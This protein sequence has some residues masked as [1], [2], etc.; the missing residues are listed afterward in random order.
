VGADVVPGGDMDPDHVEYQRAAYDSHY[1]KMAAAVRDQ[2]AHPLL[3]SFYDRLAERILDSMDFRLGHVRMFE[4]GC[5]EGLLATAVQRVALRRGRTFSYTGSDLSAA[6]I[7]LAR[8]AVEGDFLHGDAVE[9]VSGLEAGSQDL[10]WAKNLIH[11]LPNPADFL[12]EA[13]RVVGRDG[14]VVVVE[15]RMWCPMH[16]VNLIYIRQERYQFKGYR[17]TLAAFDQAGAR[18]V[19]AHEFGWLPY[20]LVLATRLGL[21]RRLLSWSTRSAIGRVSAIDDRLTSRL[22]N[23]AL[24]M[25]SELASP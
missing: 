15:P 5:G 12:R 8:T 1:P 3:S 19:S 25:V 4:A 10:I 18:L 11:H 14:R 9:V 21:P 22:P 6:G 17:R 13:M 16:W 20:E 2:L 24:Y 23:L 7:E